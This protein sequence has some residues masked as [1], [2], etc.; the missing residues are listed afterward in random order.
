MKNLNFSFEKTGILEEV[1]LN[2]AYAGAK[3]E[4]EKPIFDR[5]ATCDSDEVL[6]LKFWREMYGMITDRLRSFILSSDFSDAAFSITLELSGAYDDSLTPSVK[7]DLYAAIV[8][9]ITSRWFAFV[10]PAK[11]VEWKTE[12]ERL[13]DS[14]VSKLCHRR[15]PV[16]C[17]ANPL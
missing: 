9:G 15:R 16:R 14:V 11:A 7:N 8:A 5:V 17:I 6:L 1:S 12:S 3:S 10:C 13:F 2:T 4:E